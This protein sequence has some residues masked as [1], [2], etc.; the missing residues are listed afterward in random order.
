[1]GG[2]AA[3]ADLPSWGHPG[4]YGRGGGGWAEVRATPVPDRPRWSQAR[5][6]AAGG[7]GGRAASRR[8]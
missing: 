2:G 3:A 4:R 8:R 5:Y 7:G 1:R 6:P